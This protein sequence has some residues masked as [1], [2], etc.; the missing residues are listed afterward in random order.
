LP[1]LTQISSIKTL[2]LDDFD[3]NGLKVILIAGNDVEINSQ[4]GRLD[5]FHGLILLNDKKAFFT[6][7]KERSF[8]ISGSARDIEKININGIEYYIITINN[9]SPVFLKNND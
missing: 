3:K 7:K 4:L 1:F 9:N 6:I 8:D 2:Y 5:A